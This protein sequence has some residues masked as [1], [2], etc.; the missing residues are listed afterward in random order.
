VKGLIEK[1]AVRRR[2]ATATAYPI[3]KTI[4]RIKQVWRASTAA[5]TA[6]A[7]EFPIKMTVVLIFRG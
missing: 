5:L 7:M 4:A 1:K 3:R 2:T 6:M